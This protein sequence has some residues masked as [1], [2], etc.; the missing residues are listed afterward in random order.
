MPLCLAPQ[1]FACLA[2]SGGAHRTWNSLRALT[3]LRKHVLPG[4]S[5][6][7][8]ASCVSNPGREERRALS[9]L[10]CFPS[11]R[12][13]K[14]CW[15]LDNELLV[16]RQTTRWAVLEFPLSKT[17]WHTKNSNILTTDPIHSKVMSSIF[18]FTCWS[19][20]FKRVS[21]TLKEI[22]PPTSYSK[23]K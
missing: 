10:W 22:A 7:A 6:P 21:K 8:I 17:F 2:T 9:G 4:F 18:L 19:F 23:N 15:C 11:A 14:S 3:E 12:K 5:M 1:G 20:S 13:H 16:H